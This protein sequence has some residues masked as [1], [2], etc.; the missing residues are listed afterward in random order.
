LLPKGAIHHAAAAGLNGVFQQR[1]QP[2][3]FFLY[4]IELRDIEPAGELRH[5]TSVA[6]HELGSHRAVA[7]NP[8]LE[9]ET[10]V[11]NDRE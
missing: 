11:F 6:R 10:C 8:D 1:D 7:R 5:G 4:A 2:S 9:A 3:T